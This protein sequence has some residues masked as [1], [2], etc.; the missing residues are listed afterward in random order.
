MAIQTAE[1]YYENEDNW[2]NYQFINL[3]DF[4]DELL[5]ETTDS[6]S[7]LLNTPRSKLLV[8]SKNGIR[9][10]NKEIRK[11]VLAIEMTV[12]EQLYIVLPHRLCGMGGFCCCYGRF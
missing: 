11:T 3:K 9:K 6:D 10:L 12:G 7:Y 1:E 4:I 8:A 5:V 2:G